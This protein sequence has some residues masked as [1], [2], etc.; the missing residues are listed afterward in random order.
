MSNI[1]ASKYN[2]SRRVILFLSAAAVL[3]VVTVGGIFLYKRNGFGSTA[4]DNTEAATEAKKLIYLY[5]PNLIGKSKE[6]AVK[7]LEED[8]F[9]NIKVEY[10]TAPEELTGTVTRQSIPENTT[11]G[12]DYEI[13]IFIGK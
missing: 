1:E 12:T 3:L 4:P 6:G 5:M 13:I 7:K 10:E 11:V 2:K 9:Y 8:G